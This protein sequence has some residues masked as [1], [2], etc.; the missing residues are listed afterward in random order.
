[1]SE[2]KTPFSEY[3]EKLF[4]EMVEKGYIFAQPAWPRNSGK[5]LT[6]KEL[7][8]SFPVLPEEKSDER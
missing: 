3:A 2:E 5:E 4:K 1:M 7:S 8:V 6:F